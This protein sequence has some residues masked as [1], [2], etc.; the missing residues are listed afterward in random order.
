M[1]RWRSEYEQENPEAICFF[2]AKFMLEQVQHL[3]SQIEGVQKGKN[4]E[5]VHQMRVASRRLRSGLT[6]FRNVWRGRS[7]KSGWMMCAILPMRLATPGIWISR[8]LN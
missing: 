6:L 5:Y 7:P 8:S 2:G 3:E 4:I 1:D